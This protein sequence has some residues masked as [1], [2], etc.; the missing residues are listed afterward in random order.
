[1]IEHD[2]VSCGYHGGYSVTASI[3]PDRWVA[4]SAHIPPISQGF[5]VNTSIVYWGCKPTYSWAPPWIS[6]NSIYVYIR[7]LQMSSCNIDLSKYLVFFWPGRW[8]MNVIHGL[9]SV[10]TLRVGNGKLDLSREITWFLSQRHVGDKWWQ[11]HNHNW[12][13]GAAKSRRRLS[14]RPT[15]VRPYF[16][17]NTERC[18]LQG[19]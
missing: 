15:M 8:K 19:G 11:K 12:H 3:S 14:L 9:F 2:G 1:M 4:K 5:M 6:L 7:P 16:P 13:R 17:A 10:S 18:G